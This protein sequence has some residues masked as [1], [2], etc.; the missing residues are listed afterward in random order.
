MQ[1]TNLF[2]A[3]NI[4]GVYRYTGSAQDDGYLNSPVGQVAI[5]QAT[6]AQSFID[7]YNIRIANPGN[8]ALPRWTRLGVRFNF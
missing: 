5:D 2:D 4:L 1:I 7:L 8:Y 6:N 3:R